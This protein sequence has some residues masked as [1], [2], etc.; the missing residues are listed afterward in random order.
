MKKRKRRRNCKHCKI[1]FAPDYR[2]R[3]RQKFCK[4]P[5]CQIVRKKDSQTRWLNKPQNRNTF[6]GWANVHRVQEW[7]KLNPGYWRK[8]PL[9][10]NALQDRCY[11]QPPAIKKDT[12]TYNLTTLQDYCLSEPSVFVGLISFLTGDTLQDSIA[13]FIVKLSN[14][15]LTIMGNAPYKINQKGDGMIKNI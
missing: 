15:G 14:R 6:K 1:L 5:D 8:K 2:N 12:L 4:K 13:P 11:S 9:E 7:R 3:K 10:K